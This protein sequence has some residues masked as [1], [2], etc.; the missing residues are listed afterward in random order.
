MA[1]P[2]V[3][4]AIVWGGHV[5]GRGVLASREP[6]VVGLDEHAGVG[7]VFDRVQDAVEVVRGGVERA[8]HE[9]G[10]LVALVLV[11]VLEVADEFAVHAFV[12]ERG[13][14]SPRGSRRR[15]QR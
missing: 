12:G 6:L 5:V 3:T 1:S 7:R 8:A 10:V 14:E 4:A 15:G 9:L 13:E 11:G 2:L